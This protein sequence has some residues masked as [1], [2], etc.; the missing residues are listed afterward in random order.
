MTTST[1]SGEAREPDLDPAELSQPTQAPELSLVDPRRSKAARDGLTEKLREYLSKHRK[2]WQ[3]APPKAPFPISDALD[4]S[5]ARR[6][7]SVNIEALAEWL[8]SDTGQAAVNAEAEALTKALREI[9]KRLRVQHAVIRKGVTRW[10]DPSSTPEELKGEKPAWF[11]KLPPA[12]ETLQAWA[13]A[14]PAPEGGRAEV[15]T[16]CAALLAL[17]ELHSWHHLQALHSEEPDSDW[18]LLL[19]RAYLRAIAD[20]ERDTREPATVGYQGHSKVPKYAAAFA[21]SFG[22]PVVTEVNGDRYAYEPNLPVSPYVPRSTALLPPGWTGPH[23]TAFPFALDPKGTS[24]AEVMTDSAQCGVFHAVTAK[25]FLLAVADPHVQGGGINAT[26]ARDW[27]KRL[28]PYLPRVQ[29]RE[30]ELTAQAFH[31]ADGLTLYL[32]STATRVFSVTVPTKYD[33]KA[34]LAIAFS[35]VFRRS[36]EAFSGSPYAGEFVLNL[37][38]ALAL[39]NKSP[40][41]LRMYVRLAASW[42]AAG[43]PGKGPRYGQIDPERLEAL[44]L[45]DWGLRFNTLSHGALA[46]KRGHSSTKLRQKL[47]KDRADLVTH[48]DALAD[49]G[50]VTIEKQGRGRHTRYTPSPPIEWLEA[51]QQLRA[52]GPVDPRP[53]R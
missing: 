21:P 7:P 30:I 22:G 12:D 16:G 29:R 10:I 41:Q 44:T 39:P 17:F 35:P 13:K 49:R 46:Y 19:S 45:D 38:G 15:V 18:L 43:F 34:D 20:E 27:A 37:D 53:T 8:S 26:T 4:K 25:L 50:L 32:P 14:N 48:F 47:Y 2:A 5:L 31:Q 3:S 1:D 52:Q 33:P 40:A 9:R 28:F 36:V 6:V 24:L 42:N 23:Q 11:A 51:R